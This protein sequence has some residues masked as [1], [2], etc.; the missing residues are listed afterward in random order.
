MKKHEETTTEEQRNVV[1]HKKAK[2]SATY[3]LRA[4]GENA[5]KLYTL[6]LLTDDQLSEIIKIQKEAMEKHIRAEMGM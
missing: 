4:I 1:E 2:V 6:N 3:T 5:R